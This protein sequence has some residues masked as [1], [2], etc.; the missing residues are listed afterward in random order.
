[1]DNTQPG[2]PA[3]PR[4]RILIVDDDPVVSG[5]LADTLAE[6]GYEIVEASSRDAAR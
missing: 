1:M 4:S 5:M 2:L 3:P 6:A